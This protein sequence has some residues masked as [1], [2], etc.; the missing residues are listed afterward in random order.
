MAR[1]FVPR[2]GSPNVLEIS[3]RN[4]MK[5]FFE[6]STNQNAYWIENGWNMERLLFILEMTVNK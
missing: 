6:A 4:T 5:S 2:C 3:L 1:I